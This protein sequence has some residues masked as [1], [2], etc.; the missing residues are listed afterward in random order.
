[1]IKPVRKS[2]LRLRSVYCPGR[3]LRTWRGDG[4]Q[5]SDAEAEVFLNWVDAAMGERWEIVYED[6]GNR[7]VRK[8][9]AIAGKET[10]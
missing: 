5:F 8:S 10:P 3:S 4:A 1:M 2:T 7:F 6:A 9:A